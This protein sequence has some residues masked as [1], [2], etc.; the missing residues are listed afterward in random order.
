MR[1][2]MTDPATWQ[3]Q[4]DADIEAL[5]TDRL[6]PAILDAQQRAVPVLTG[7]LLA[8]LGMETVNEGRIELHVGS[9]LEN[10]PYALAVEFGFHGLEHVRAYETKGGRHV[11][12]HTRRGNSPEQPYMRPSLYQVRAP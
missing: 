7:R 3:P 6:G 4:L 1:I 10:V 8:S 11:R 12:A 5:F 2:E 9:I